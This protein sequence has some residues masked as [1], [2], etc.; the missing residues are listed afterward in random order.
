MNI[1]K[2]ESPVDSYKLLEE[3]D[4]DPRDSDLFKTISRQ[5]DES[6]V[7]GLVSSTQRGWKW[8]D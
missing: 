1:L 7:Y 2:R 8:L 5:L 4:I 3:L 6:K